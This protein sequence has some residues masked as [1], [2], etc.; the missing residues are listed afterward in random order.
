MTLNETSLQVRSFARYSASLKHEKFHAEEE[1]RIVLVRGDEQVF[2]TAKFRRV[3]SLI[4]P[5]ICIPLKLNS[6]S[7][8]IDRIVVGPTPHMAE[9]KQ[10]IEMLLKR[11]GVKFEEVVESRVPYRNW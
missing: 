6:Q 8:E 11:Y 3:K 2:S 1:W 5:Y 9:G 7:I 10:S 4:V